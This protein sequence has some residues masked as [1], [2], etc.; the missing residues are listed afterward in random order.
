VRSIIF[1]RVF[2]SFFIANVV[3]G[4]GSVGHK[5]IAYIAED[6]LKPEA[7][8]K[9]LAILGVSDLSSIAAWADGIRGQRPETSGWHYVD[10]DVRTDQ[11]VDTISNYCVNDNCVVNQV[12]KEIEELKIAEKDGTLDDAVRENLK[13]L[14]HFVGDLHQPL[15]C[16]NDDDWGGNG[17]TVL[18][19]DPDGGGQGTEGNLHAIWDHL[20]EDYT[21]EDSQELACQL[22]SSITKDKE[23][24]WVLGTVESWAFDAYKIARDK[25]YPGFTPGPTP[26]DTVVALSRDYYSEMRPI[27]D[28]LMEKAGIRLANILNNIYFPQTQ[29]VETVSE[30]AKV[31]P[32]LFCTETEAVL[33]NTSASESNIRIKV[34]N[35]MGK[36]VLETKVVSVPANSSLH[37]S[38]DFAN[39]DNG[40]Y[41]V[42]IYDGKA[43]PKTIKIVKNKT[44]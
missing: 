40:V 9:V 15:H 10:I 31:F 18:L 22:E 38:L 28:E 14:I 2:F 7:K 37:V 35:L 13:F 6:N 36:T 42:S 23:E 8:Q 17:K 16:S 3:F 41:F 12:K 32:T 29:S 33:V 1:K 44:Q 39:V 26:T 21:V 30:T 24:E 25:I 34:H 4:Y 43:K 19:F 11:T 5:T 20:I 27:E